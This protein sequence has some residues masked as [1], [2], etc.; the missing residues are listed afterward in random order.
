MKVFLV[1]DTDGE[2]NAY[3]A[4]S[5]Y[6][7]AYRWIKTRQNEDIIQRQ[8]Q[9]WTEEQLEVFKEYHADPDELHPYDIQEIEVD[10][11]Y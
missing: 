2:G 10:E 9:G 1:N 7:L 8:K 6:P 4:A 3:Y 5:T 11:K